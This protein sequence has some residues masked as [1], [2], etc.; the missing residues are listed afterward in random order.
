MLPTP[1]QIRSFQRDGFVAIGP[2]VDETALAGLRD[3][4]E[5]LERR[6]AAELDVTVERYRT[7]V[8]QWTGLWEQHHAFAVQ[9]HHPAIERVARALLGVERLQ[10]FH[11]H[12]ISK[13]PAHSS[14][15]PW[16]QDYPFWPVNAPRALSC[17][18]SLD[19]ATAD[20]GALHF[21]P[22][23]HRD[24][25]KP[26]VDFLAHNKDWGPR[27]KDA[28]AVPVEAGQVIFHDCLSWHYS[29]PNHTDRPRRA[30]IAIYMDADC[31]WAPAHSGWHPMNELV[32][33]GPGEHFNTDR[34]PTIRRADLDEA[35]P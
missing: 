20:S 14:T 8:S 24:G 31:R 26:P 28:V 32:S 30:F 5:A 9:I 15:V 29:P 19:G 18:L 6:W 16:H 33:V 7:V 3:A 23:A 35:S 11:D 27:A 34:F 17:W 12:L 10:L 4:F 1:E 13:P 2:L 21:M 25:E 22:G